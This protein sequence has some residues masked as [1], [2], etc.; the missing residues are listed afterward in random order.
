M[1]PLLKGYV[2]AC[3]SILSNEQRKVDG[4]KLKKPEGNFLCIAMSE[5]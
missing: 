4:R 3:I 2:V 5:L 1:F